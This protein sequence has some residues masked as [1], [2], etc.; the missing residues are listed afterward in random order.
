[1]GLRRRRGALKRL[2]NGGDAGDPREDTKPPGAFCPPPDHQARWGSRPER[3]CPEDRPCRRQED[4]PCLAAAR[5]R[6][7]VKPPGALLPGGPPMPPPGGPPMPPGGGPARDG[8]KPPER[9]CPEDRPCRRQE[10]RPCR[11]AAARLAT[12]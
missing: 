6:D 1:M 8:V 5:P 3:C 9:C 2:T 7:G 10:D 4:R 12:A 11:L